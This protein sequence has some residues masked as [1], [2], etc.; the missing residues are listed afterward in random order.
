MDGLVMN[1]KILTPTQANGTY[2]A[3]RL[4]SYVQGHFRG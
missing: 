4:I 3:A 1:E 2:L